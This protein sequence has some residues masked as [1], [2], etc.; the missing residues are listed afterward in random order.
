MCRVRAIFIANANAKQQ[1]LLRFLWV[2]DVGSLEPRVEVYRVTRAC[3]G[4]ISSPYF[5]NATIRHHLSK[6]EEANREFVE[7][8]IQSLYYDDYVSS[9]DSEDEAFAQF[10]NLKQCFR[11]AGFNMR[12]WKL[13][14]NELTSKIKTEEKKCLF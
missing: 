5:L 12:K 4:V 9:F 6:Y 14:S 11:E 1:D 3:F 2:D 13:N 8:V 7:N 10:Q